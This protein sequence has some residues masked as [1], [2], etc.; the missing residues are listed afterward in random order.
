MMNHYEVNVSL[1][2]KHFFATDARSIITQDDLR[3]VYPALKEAF[4]EVKGYQLRVTYWKG[5]GEQVDVS[6]L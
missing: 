5:M 2:G 6:T 1:N 4:P 3:R